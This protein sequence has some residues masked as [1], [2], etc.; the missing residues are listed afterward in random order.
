MESQGG[1]TLIRAGSWTRG[2][3][4][5]GKGGSENLDDGESTRL[6]IRQLGTWGC[7]CRGCT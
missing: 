7:T 6:R 5:A 2:R 3:T 4:G 1:R